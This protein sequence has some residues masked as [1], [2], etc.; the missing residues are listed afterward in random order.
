MP[1]LVLCACA[2]LARTSARHRADRAAARRPWRR[3]AHRLACQHA[4]LCPPRAPPP[5]R[6]ADSVRGPRR[7]AVQPVG[8]QP[9][10]QPAGLTRQSRLHRRRPQGPCPGRGRHPHREGLRHRPV[11]LARFRD[12]F[13]VAGRCPARGHPAGLAA[14]AGLGRRPGPRR[15]QDPA[16]QDLARRRAAGPR[17]ATA[18]AEN[19]QN[20]ALGHRNSHRLGPDQRPTASPMN[21]AKPSPRS[22][23]EQR[24][25]P[26]NPRPP[27]PPTG[28]L[29][30][31]NPTIKIFH[32]A[33][34]PF[35]ASHRPARMIR[36]SATSA[37]RR[38]E[39]CGRGWPRVCRT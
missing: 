5:G 4:G 27:G 33:L 17:R 14:A 16:L 36:A 39:G 15:A 12:Q 18:P 9:A 22:R 3:P 37:R 26:W 1:G 34:C 2:V 23:K 11:S 6:P 7:L 20:L 35:Q 31:P 32:E 30:Y 25:G 19:L 8:D 21:N 10:R 38:I 24:R 29:S 28:L 13:G